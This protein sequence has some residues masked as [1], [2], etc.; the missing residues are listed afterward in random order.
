MTIWFT[1]D[2]HFNH[3]NIIKYTNRPFDDVEQMDAEQIHRWNEK[4][5]LNDTVYHLGDFALARRE[6]AYRYFGQLNGRIKVLAYPWHHD[7]RWLPNHYGPVDIIS[8]SNWRI[9]L[10]PPMVVLELR[11][12]SDG[13]YP[14]A[15]VLCHYQIKK[16]ERKHYDS[17]HLF[18][19]SHGKVKGEGLSFD[20]GVDCWGFAPIPLHKVAE[21]M[22]E[23]EKEAIEQPFPYPAFSKQT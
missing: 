15:L 19:H 20:V 5:K 11:Q 21:I 12:Y 8:A 18:G 1:S 4:V 22:E 17:W 10:L 23:K 6:Q 9:E 16:W 3:G 14:R 2:Q 7:K 13:K